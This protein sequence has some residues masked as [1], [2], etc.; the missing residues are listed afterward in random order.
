MFYIRL[1]ISVLLSAILL[2][3]TL[4]A[5]EMAQPSGGMAALVFIP[6]AASV[7]AAHYLVYSR[8]YQARQDVELQP[9]TFLRYIPAGH[10]KALTRAVLF[11]PASF[12]ILAFETLYSGFRELVMAFLLCGFSGAVFLFL[13]SSLMPAHFRA[14]YDDAKSADLG[15]LVGALP[16][17]GVVCLLV[18][19]GDMPGDARHEDLG[20]WILAKAK[21]RIPAP[22]GLK[23][24]LL[25]SVVD[26]EAAGEAARQKLVDYLGEAQWARVFYCVYG[27]IVCL[28]V[29]RMGVFCAMF[30]HCAVALLGIGNSP[31]KPGSR[32]PAAKADA[33]PGLRKRLAGFLASRK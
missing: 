19:A 11:I 13:R 6:L 22:E 23:A 15:A 12:A 25:G 10:C 30:V 5:W 4:F 24:A 33:K 16:F 21:D 7:L 27:A 9:D 29:A 20:D 2:S 32:K 18:H 31:E 14:P 28:I 8:L 26:L 1:G 3:A 17:V